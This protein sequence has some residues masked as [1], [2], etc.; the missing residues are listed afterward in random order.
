MTISL[1]LEW[2]TLVALAF[3]PGA[4]LAFAVTPRH[5]RMRRVALI[6]SPSITYG[7]IGIAVAWSG[8]AGATWSP[9]TVLWFELS[10]AAAALT[11]NLVLR[12]R[13]RRPG[14]GASRSRL[15]H[16]L[17]VHAA[18]LA[19]LGLAAAAALVVAWFLVGR[20]PSAPG[21]DAMNHAFLMSRVLSSG[22]GLASQVCVTGDI[23]FTSSCGFYPLAPHVLW[24]QASQLTGAGPTAVILASTWLV[25]PLTAV[26]GVFGITRVLGAR[27]AVAGAA[28]F[29]PML[30]GPLWPSLATGRLTVLLGAALVPSVALLFWLA[31]RIPRAPAVLALAAIALAGMF[32]T[33]TYDA[34]GAALLLLGLL[35]TSLS[36]RSW[37]GW[38][39]LVVAGGLSLVLMIPNLVLLLVA[40]SERLADRTGAPGRP[41]WE[42]VAQATFPQGGPIGTLFDPVPR[43]GGIPISL[44]GVGVAVSAVLTALLLVGMTASL[45]PAF[46]WARPFAVL[47]LGMLVV[48]VFVAVDLGPVH[49]VVASLFYDDPRRVLWS[50][51]LAPGALTLAGAVAAVQMALLVARAPARR[52]RLARGPDTGNPPLIPGRQPP[53]PETAEPLDVA[54]AS[55]AQGRRQ[56]RVGVA[57]AVCLSALVLA[58]PETAMAH[59]RFAA[60]AMPDDPAYARTTE[61]LRGRSG[62]VAEDFHRDFVPWMTVDAGL[63]LLRGIEPLSGPEEAEW[64]RR[65][66]LWKTLIG[67]RKSPTACLV[68]DYD[69]SWVVV[70]RP[71]M[72]G[73]RRTWNINKL[74]RSPFLR[75]VRVDGPVRVYAVHDPCASR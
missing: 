70:G 48:A 17:R 45:L 9:L 2:A 28:A 61:W 65:V 26:T 35:V 51:A 52:R 40:R 11:V 1:L 69:V 20:L 41:F 14:W 71:A 32:V 46:R 6:A 30:I 68:N 63:P 50:S 47:H 19:A 10:A 42:V 43:P 29:L 15:V 3:L 57:A 23:A 75:L 55:R 59:E 27:P 34:L 13:R 39:R 60:R 18:D 62:S 44:S 33:H 5:S 73:G 37:R 36:W 72:P 22:S 24:A 25:T 54:A 8:Y 49:T 4:A 38:A 31:A 16:R 7:L 66:Q 64:Q 12:H 21:W 67:A 56:S 58:V 74:T 53:G